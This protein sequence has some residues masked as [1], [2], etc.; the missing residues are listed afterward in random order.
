MRNVAFVMT[1]LWCGCGDD[2]PALPDTPTPTPDAPPDAGPSLDDFPDEERAVLDTLTP[3]P[4]VPADPTNAFADD[5][6]AAA[7]G[8]MLFFDKSFSGPL[9]VGD[10]GMNGGVGRV[11][12][13]DKVSCHSC[14]A[15][16][17]TSLDDRRSLPNNV[18]LGTNFTPRNAL[19]L[20]NSAFYKWTIWAGRF[21]SQWSLPLA[22]TEGGATMNGT[23]LEVVHILT[24]KYR[25]EYDAIFP[26]PL[27]PRLDPTHPNAAEL[28]A[29]GKPGQ[30]AFD[31]LPQ[32]DKDIVNRIYANYGKA[33]AAYMR[34]LVSRN[35]P[36]DRYLAGELTA[37]SD[38]AK[39]G[40]RLFIKHCESCHSGPNFADDDFHV[41]GVVQTGP[42]V[43]ATDN[44]RNQDVPPL[45]A[46]A[47]NVNGPFSD[48]TQTGKLD[49]LVQAD[50]QKGQFR[51]KS[52]R[53]LDGSGPYMHTGGLATLEDVVAFYNAGGGDVTAAGFVKDARIVPLGLSAEQ[54]ADLVAFLK[55]LNGESVPLERMIDTS[56]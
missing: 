15:I 39:R 38:S 30:P 1:V 19:G 40:V 53:T 8:Q 12:D 7:L 36:F 5:P 35:A 52:L 21:D 37:I 14:H 23:R 41:I 55:T 28:P 10:D 18:S 51:T 11:G 29:T 47:F 13:V 4:A 17:S 25:A 33:I 9:V 49:G 56:K 31:N 3:L 22:V 50:S 34:T 6:R 46:S 32:A 26:V 16:G 45:L 42:H 27:D 43:P 54:Q 2:A 44:G 24:A 20:V 48:N